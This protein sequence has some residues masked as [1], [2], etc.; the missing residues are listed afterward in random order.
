[1]LLH[2]QLQVSRIQVF[3]YE[4]QINYGRGTLFETDKNNAHRLGTGKIVL[5]RHR[6]FRTRLNNRPVQWARNGRFHL[7]CQFCNGISSGSKYCVIPIVT[8]CAVTHELVRN[9]E[10]LACPSNLAH[11]TVRCAMRIHSFAIS[12]DYH[13]PRGYDQRNCS[14]V[15]LHAQRQSYRQRARDHASVLHPAPRDADTGRLLSRR[16]AQAVSGKR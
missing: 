16:L 8:G 15:Q 11:L 3:N 13:E 5:E 4:C 14:G 9:I 7:R 10:N 6:I 2:S 1:M 12:S